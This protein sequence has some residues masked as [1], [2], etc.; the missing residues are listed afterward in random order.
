MKSHPATTLLV[1]LGTVAV[2]AGVFRATYASAQRAG[3]PPETGPATTTFQ[4]REI[5]NTVEEIL[6]PKH[7]VLVVHEMLNDFISVG[8]ASD[9]AGRKFQADHIVD[10]IAKL[11][12]AARAKN[13][14]V[15]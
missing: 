9:K 13:V 2:T 14:R 4:G 8:G 7:T 5:P 3:G 15:A 12:T 1:V 10:P 11:L 6:N